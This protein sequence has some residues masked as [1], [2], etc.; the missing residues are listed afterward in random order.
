MIFAAITSK[1]RAV[2]QQV[3]SGLV[4]HSLD[5]ADALLKQY[6]AL[7]ERSPDEL[8]CWAVLRDA[9][10]LPSGRPPSTRCSLL[11]LPGRARRLP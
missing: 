8:T 3:L 9:P 1:L 6:S 5:G 4:V 7:L 11:S 2:G 10:P